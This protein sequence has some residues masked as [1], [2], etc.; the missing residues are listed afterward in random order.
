MISLLLFTVFGIFIQHS[1]KGRL[2]H[3]KMD[4]VEGLYHSLIVKKWDCMDFG[5]DWVN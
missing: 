3:C 2:F 5:G 1:I 4:N